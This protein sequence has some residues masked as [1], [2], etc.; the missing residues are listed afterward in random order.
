MSNTL[1]GNFNKSA[2]DG[3][4]GGGNQIPK[5]YYACL[6][7]DAGTDTS[8]GG[9]PMIV[10][11]WKINKQ[12]KNPD[13]K[14]SE[15]VR[16]EETRGKIV[17][18]TYSY[19]SEF[20]M[21]QLGA[22][23]ARIG[24]DPLNIQEIAN[25]EGDDAA[26]QEMVDF[27]QD[28]ADEGSVRRLLRVVPQ[29][30]DPK[31]NNVYLQDT[32]SQKDAHKTPAADPGFDDEDLAAEEAEKAAAAKEEGAKKKKAADA[33]AKR[34]KARADK[35]AARAA[36]A[37]KPTEEPKAENPVEDAE[38]VEPEETATA[39]DAGGDDEDPFAGL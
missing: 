27:M 3:L 5:G 38:V 21:Q 37:P 7:I 10:L 22:D 15:Y 12:T 14:D 33:K 9:K 28:Q 16:S 11:K 8:N 36:A 25:T 34:D 1:F 6:L 20:G 32:P 31:Y 26:L 19:L 17:K 4:K 18:V 39:D 35:K 29:K 24:G 30:K 13:D 2:K 23:F